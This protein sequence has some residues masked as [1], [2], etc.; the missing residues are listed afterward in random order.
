[1]NKAKLEF[2]ARITT[3]DGKVIEQTVEAVGGIP[4]LDDFDTST[5]EGFL[6]SFDAFEKVTLEAR[7]RIAEE[8]SEKYLEEVAKKNLIIP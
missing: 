1:M 4:D 2:V 8:I 7:N 5:R 3:P 6:S